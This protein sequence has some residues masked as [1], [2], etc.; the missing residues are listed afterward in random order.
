MSAA[1]AE[2]GVATAVEGKGQ[3]E[4]KGEAVDARGFKA[5]AEASAEGVEASKVGG[6][7]A[8][9]GGVDEKYVLEGDPF[10]AQRGDAVF[11]VGVP[12]M[13]S[14]KAHVGKGADLVEA[15]DIELV[16]RGGGPG[17]AEAKAGQEITLVGQADGAAEDGV[18]GQERVGRTQGLGGAIDLEIEGYATHDEAQLVHLSD[19]GEKAWSKEA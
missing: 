15:T 12:S 13:G 2:G 7:I 19:A 10:I 1:K 17:A 9:G 4:A 18:G 3:V 6:G 14:A 16:L 8:D 5:K 11:G